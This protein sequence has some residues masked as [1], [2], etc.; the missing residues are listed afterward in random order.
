MRIYPTLFAKFYDG[1]IHSFEEKISPDRENFLKDL[2]GKIID[3]GSGTGA[4]FKYF[5]AE[6]EVLAVEPALEMLNK[7]KEK[8]QGKNIK[9]IHLGINDEA[10]ENY[11]EPKSIDAI[12]CTLV[13]C[14]IPNPELAIS[15]LKKWLKPDGKLII[16]EHICSEKSINLKFQNLVNPVWKK[17]A[18]G[19]NLNRNTEK[20]LAESGFKSENATTFHLGLRIVKGIYTF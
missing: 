19:C 20:L 11:F 18:E 17:F 7:S 4:N 13:L 16:I 5:N 10:L 15:N 3:V 9:L 14:T 2:K 8:I 12:V 6:A 1:V